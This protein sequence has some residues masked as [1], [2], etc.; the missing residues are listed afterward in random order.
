MKKTTYSLLWAIALFLLAAVL[1]FVNLPAKAPPAGADVGELLPEFRITCTDGTE[2]QLS[3]QRGKV[4]VINLWAT[5]C[6][7]C[8]KELPNF[9]RLLREHGSE[10]AVLAVH[11]PPVTTDVSAYLKESSYSLPFAVDESGSVS[12]LLGAS[13]VLP[14]TVVL[15]PD[16]VVTYNQSGAL[17]YE[18]LLSL[19][20]AAARRE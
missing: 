17:D 15:D 7:P 12:A 13:T 16:G 8:V 14:Q 3:G 9:D 11:S 6:A 1:V 5:W 20:A 18:Q 19:V 2:F 4:T 10:I